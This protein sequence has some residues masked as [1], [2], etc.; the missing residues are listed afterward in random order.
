MEYQWSDY[1]FIWHIHCFCCVFFF[2]LLFKVF[3]CSRNRRCSCFKKAPKHI[4]D[5][6]TNSLWA[7]HSSFSHHWLGSSRTSM[8]SSCCLN[9]L[10]S[11]THWKP[12]RLTF[13]PNNKGNFSELHFLDCTPEKQLPTVLTYGEERLRPRH[14][15]LEGHYLLTSSPD[16]ICS[17]LSCISRGN[18][19][20]RE[21]QCSCRGLPSAGFML[22]SNKTHPLYKRN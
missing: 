4:S 7:T 16:N 5:I 6:T 9:F 12:S 20:S 18:G 3:K 8:P 2:L 21:T 19:R 1:N 15:K 17:A 14:I 13:V 10:P 22:P 11:R